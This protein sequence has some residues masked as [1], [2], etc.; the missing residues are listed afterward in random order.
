MVHATAEFG[1]D[2]TR[3]QH[4]RGTLSVARGGN[5]PPLHKSKPMVKRQEKG[6]F[7]ED[8]SQVNTEHFFQKWNFTSGNLEMPH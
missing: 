5:R 2:S 3:S 1:M 8:L 6:L 7:R 4:E